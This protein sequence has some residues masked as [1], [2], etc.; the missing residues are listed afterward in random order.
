M[1]LRRTTVCYVLPR[2]SSEQERGRGRSRRAGLGA[3]VGPGAAGTG[4]GAAGEGLEAAGAAKSSRPALSINRW[5]ILKHT[6]R[7]EKHTSQRHPPNTLRKIRGLTIVYCGVLL[8][9]SLYYVV[10]RCTVP[11]ASVY[12]GRRGSA[13]VSMCL[14]SH[15][16]SD[17]SILTFPHMNCLRFS[18]KACS[19][20]S[21]FEQ[22]STRHL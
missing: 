4:Q 13:L 9:S 6:I 8:C 21:T 7:M 2:T 11:Q 3:G 16:H 1:A 18:C 22:V 19:Q 17:T 14:S 20:T 15:L 12:T 10:I 5:R